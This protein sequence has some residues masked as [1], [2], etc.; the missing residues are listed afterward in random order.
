[1][2]PDPVARL[3]RCVQTFDEPE[4]AEPGL[5]GVAGGESAPQN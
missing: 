5:A 1:M 3:G 4:Q 2:L